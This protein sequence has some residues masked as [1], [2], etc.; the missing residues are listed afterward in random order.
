MLDNRSCV[1]LVRRVC[2]LFCE[3]RKFIHVKREAL[4][5]DY[6]PVELVDLYKGYHSVNIQPHNAIQYCDSLDLRH[7]CIATKQY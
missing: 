2:P 3:L 5:V 6:M 4:A 7:K 1:N